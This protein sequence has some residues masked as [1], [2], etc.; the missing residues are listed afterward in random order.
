M[1]F[2]DH[3]LEPYRYP[4]KV[5]KTEKMSFFPRDLQLSKFRKLNSVAD[6]EYVKI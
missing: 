2:L 1:L 3:V 6:H 4:F 5:S